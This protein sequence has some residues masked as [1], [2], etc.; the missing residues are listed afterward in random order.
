[1]HS[2]IDL[3]SFQWPQSIR[4][5]NDLNREVKEAIYRTLVPEGLLEQFGIDPCDATQLQ[6]LC[7]AD[8][9]SVEMA[10]YIGPDEHDPIFYLHMADTLN[11]Q[12]SLL[13]LVIN[14]PESPRFNVDVDQ[15]GLPTRFGTL[16]RNIAEELRAMEHGLAPGQIRRGLRISHMA[17]ATLERFITR[18]G[19]DLVI[20]DPLYYHNAVV[21]ERYGFT[22]FQ[23]RRRMEW[24]NQ[25]LRPGGEFFD[26]L[27]GSTPFRQPDAW[28]SIRGRAW[29][30]H[31]GVLGEPF[32]ELHMYKRVGYEAGVNTFPDGVW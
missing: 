3:D 20:I 26:R 19:H 12:I 30:I 11:Y 27:D 9:R 2:P 15:N 5:I 16:R 23:G 17:V 25:V 32:G 31:D 14:D 8:T 21:Y 10:A 28:K 7:P 13:L 29:A 22:Y 18:T 4:S 6:I 1:M 24:I